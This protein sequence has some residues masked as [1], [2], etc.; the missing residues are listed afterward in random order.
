MNLFVERPPIPKTE[1]Y[2]IVEGGLDL[3]SKE[4]K[5]GVIRE[6]ECGLIM[7]YPTMKAIHKWLESKIN[8]FERLYLPKKP[9]QE[10]IEQ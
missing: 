9:T 10:N 4:E 6:V 1:N 5:E 3:H 7:D 8:T 2:N